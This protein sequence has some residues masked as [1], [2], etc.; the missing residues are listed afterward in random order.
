MEESTKGVWS[1]RDIQ[2]SKDIWPLRMRDGGGL[3]NGGRG[4]AIVVDHGAG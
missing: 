1:S 2:L 3:T 4:D